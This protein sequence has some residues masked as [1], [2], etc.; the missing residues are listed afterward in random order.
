LLKHR[1]ELL[2]EIRRIER[3]VDEADRVLAT[4]IAEAA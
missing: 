3:L 1:T 2:S 4:P